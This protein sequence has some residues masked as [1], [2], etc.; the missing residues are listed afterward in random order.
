MLE[1]HRNRVACRNADAFPAQQ[2]GFVQLAPVLIR[3]A[4]LQL[5]QLVQPGLDV[6][7]AQRPVQT[8]GR[9]RLAG[10]GGQQHLDGAAGLREGED[11]PLGARPGAQQIE[12]LGAVVHPAIRRRRQQTGLE[13]RG[14]GGL[15]LGQLLFQQ[16]ESGDQIPARRLMLA[17]LLFEALQLAPY[18]AQGLFAPLGMGDA[19]LRRADQGPAIQPDDIG[20]ALVAGSLL[21]S[22]LGSRTSM[23]PGLGRRLG[24]TARTGLLNLHPGSLDRLRACS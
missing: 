19:L 7:L 15:R 10:I 11:Q 14:Q 5:A 6:L 20:L 13:L 18:L 12:P 22:G 24:H 3:H 23:Q 8:G 9:L 21:G 2:H 1:L 16:L 4:Q 17:Q